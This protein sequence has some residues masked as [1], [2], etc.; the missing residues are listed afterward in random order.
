MGVTIVASVFVF[1]LL[2]FFHELGHFLV[3]KKMGIKVK[4]FAMGFGPKVVSWK[5]EETTYCWRIFPLGGFVR[6]TG[7]DPE[8]SDE[9]D[10]F[11]SQSVRNRFLTIIAGPLMNFLLAVV[12]FFTIY[13]AFL[14][15]TTF[16]VQ[17][18]QVFLEGR[19]AE[20]GLQIKDTILTI[21]EKSVETWEQVVR[22]INAHPEKEI[23]IVI[24]RDKEVLNF[25]LLPEK[26][27]ET[28]H[29]LI[30]IGPET[31]RFRLLPSLQLGVKNTVM[32][33][34][35]IFDSLVKMF[36]GEIPA[37]IAGPVGIV[38]IVGEV[39]QTGIVNLLSLAAVLSINLGLLNLLPIPAL[40]GSR[41]IFLIIE[42]IRKRPVDPKKENFI[43]FIGFS[44]LILLMI[45]VTYKDIIRLLF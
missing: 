24:E 28:G 15:V 42:A 29:G 14:G 39:A 35:F 4:E 31:V 19:A 17:I 22:E 32:F 30:G 5:S 8:E 9:P 1:G 37:N 10:S 20:A 33:V 40:D 6:M 38:S 44:L 21:N 41:L 2:I 16:P 12:L 7:E 18:G 3:A 43:H 27:P 13:F 26:D 36:M 23:R 34:A 11:Q 25:S 45:A